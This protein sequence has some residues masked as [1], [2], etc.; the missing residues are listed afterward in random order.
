MDVRDVCVWTHGSGQPPSPNPTRSHPTPAQ[1]HAPSSCSASCMRTA[2]RRLK[3]ASARHRS[4]SWRRDSKWC[5]SWSEDDDD[6]GGC[7]LLYWYPCVWVHVWVWCQAGACFEDRQAG[8]RQDA[9]R[10]QSSDKKRGDDDVQVS[11]PASPASTTLDLPKQG[12]NQSAHLRSI[13]RRM[14][15]GGW[16]MRP[17]RLRA[18]VRISFFVDRDGHPHPSIQS[19]VVSDACVS[20]LPP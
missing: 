1:P 2:R 12:E 15:N 5:C 10:L 13:A 17:N 4:P 8:R 6:G 20:D 11:Q 16:W 14:S 3:R 7:I 19:S 18:L 9:R